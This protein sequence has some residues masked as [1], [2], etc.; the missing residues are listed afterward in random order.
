MAGTEETSTTETSTQETST[1]TATKSETTTPIFSP[2]QQTLIDGMLKKA[3]TDNNTFRDTQEKGLKENRDDILSDLKK[4]QEKT[5]DLEL[6]KRMMDGNVEEVTKEIT[7]RV[8]GEYKERLTNSKNEFD[9]LKKQNDNNTINS[10]LDAHLTD[11][12]V[13]DS[14]KGARRKELLLD[15]KIELSETG[16][17]TI[18]GLSLEDF[19]K[20]WLENGA[21]VNDWIK[22]DTMSGGGAQGGRGKVI[23]SNAGVLAGLSGKQRFE[24][25]AKMMGK[26]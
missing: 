12:G 20:Q 8:E 7:A 1:D 13:K 3:V 19:G 25:A 9:N 24:A 5:R 18:D 6:K 10:A 17:V 22:A 11:L 26:K 14:L 4:S 21:N 16:T 23:T 2:E 15:S